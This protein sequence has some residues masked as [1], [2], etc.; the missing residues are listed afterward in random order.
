MNWSWAEAH[1]PVD[2]VK[3]NV[4]ISYTRLFG[5]QMNLFTL[6]SVLTPYSLTLQ[7]QIGTNHGPKGRLDENM[8]MSLMIESTLINQIWLSAASQKPMLKQTIDRRV[9]T[10]NSW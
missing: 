5:K 10:E 3:R 2:A 7:C 9:P 6:L 8:L 1:K 4:P